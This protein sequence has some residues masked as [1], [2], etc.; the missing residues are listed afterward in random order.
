MWSYF[1]SPFIIDAASRFHCLFIGSMI[2]KFLEDYGS[3]PA[4]Q[5]NFIRGR[6]E[7]H[8][9]TLKFTFASQLGLTIK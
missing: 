3:A 6:F 7:F 2:K 1:H 9:G 4:I 5:L 8:C